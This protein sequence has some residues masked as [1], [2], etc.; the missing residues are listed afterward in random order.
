MSLSKT[1]MWFSL[2]DSFNL[3]KFSHQHLLFLSW[4]V[5]VQLCWEPLHVVSRQLAAD[6]SAKI[7]NLCSIQPFHITRQL[8]LQLMITSLL[9][10]CLVYEMLKKNS[11]KNCIHNFLE[12]MLMSRTWRYLIHCHIWRRK[13]ATSSYMKSWK[14]KILGIFALKMTET[15][16]Q[17]SKQQQMNFLSID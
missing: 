17:S 10:N 14:Q 5:S 12:A 15:I 16:I 3:F 4:V 1:N 9:I 13:T 8:A 6:Q 7:I 2:Q 11:G